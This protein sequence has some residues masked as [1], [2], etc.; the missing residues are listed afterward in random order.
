MGGNNAFYENFERNKYLKNL[1]S[2]HRVY[3]SIVSA[4][5]QARLFT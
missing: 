4:W 2:M 3:I 5:L 1:P